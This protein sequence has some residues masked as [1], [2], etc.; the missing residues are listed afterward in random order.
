MLKGVILNE[1]ELVD[2]F[3]ENYIFV[4]GVKKTD[5]IRLVMR[6]YYTDSKEEDKVLITKEEIFN[7]LISDLKKGLREEFVYTKWQKT[8]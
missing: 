2:N 3:L 5:I 6:K 7:R 4:E 8:Y 1:V